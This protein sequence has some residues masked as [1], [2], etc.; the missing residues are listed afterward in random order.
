MM[1]NENLDSVIKNFGEDLKNEYLN[2]KESV[3]TVEISA[4][5]DRRILDAI[6]KELSEKKLRISRKNMFVFFLAAVLI[7]AMSIGI[8]AVK[9]SIENAKIKEY[10]HKGTNTNSV[11]FDLE[12]EEPVESEYHRSSLLPTY[13][14]EGMNLHYYRNFDT[15]HEAEESE[16]NYNYSIWIGYTNNG[17]TTS[18]SFECYPIAEN[19]V[20]T[21]IGV[22]D[23]HNI[24]TDISVCGYRG[25]LCN[26]SDNST[27]PCDLVWHDE[28]Y[29]YM[30]SSWDK[31]ITVE[32]LLKIAESLYSKNQ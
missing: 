11:F 8:Y 7:L 20:G 32:E 1:S 4:E 2:S 21:G 25:V 14:P 24:Y 15:E 18:Y 13:I 12:T 23:G 28:N 29:K 22:A 27:N 6:E 19:C 30:I 10:V 31:E 9:T 17:K 16:Y 26:N 3:K 5:T